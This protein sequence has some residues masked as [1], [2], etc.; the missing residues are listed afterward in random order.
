MLI[1]YFKYISSIS[2]VKIKLQ[3]IFNFHRK[4]FGC[5]VTK[6]LERKILE[7]NVMA[8]HLREKLFQV[9]WVHSILYDG[10]KKYIERLK[11]G[12]ACSECMNGTLWRLS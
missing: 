9:H 4:D 5:K 6:I 12:C 11:Y 10:Y 3:S 7:E 1:F 8:I 2:Q